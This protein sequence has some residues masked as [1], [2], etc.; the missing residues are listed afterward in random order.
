[1]RITEFIKALNTKMPFQTKDNNISEKNK[2]ENKKL[3]QEIGIKIISLL[4]WNEDIT[5]LQIMYHIQDWEFR[6]NAIL[7]PK[8][9]AKKEAIK[10]FYRYK[11]CGYIDEWNN[12]RE[13]LVSY[14]A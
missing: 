14:I 2:E 7:M 11:S 6:N 4:K 1:M 9:Q 10:T 8:E 5:V 12:I 13:D 3:T